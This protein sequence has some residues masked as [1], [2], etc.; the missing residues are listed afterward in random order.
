MVAHVP[1]LSE[2]CRLKLQTLPKRGEWVY[3]KG[4]FALSERPPLWSLR[5]LCVIF[6]SSSYEAGGRAGESHA[7]KEAITVECVEWQEG[8]ERR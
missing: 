3:E 5:R 6:I 8:T 1:G 7:S 4:Y 2:G